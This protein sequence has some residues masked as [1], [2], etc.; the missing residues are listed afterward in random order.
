MEELT[1]IVKRILQMIPVLLIITFIIFFGMRLI[2]GDPAL[3]LVGNRASDEVIAATRAR[4]GSDE[5]LFTQYLL[6]L[7]QCL[8]FDFGES[9]T[10]RAPVTELFAQKAVITVSLTLMT[11]VF[12][13]LISFPLGYAA[14]VKHDSKIGSFIDS[15]SLTFVSVPEF[16]VGLVIMLI[17]ALRLKWFPVGGWGDTLG[18]RLHAL[19]LPAF[20]GALG[21]AAL[22][23]RNIRGNVIQVLD[24]DYVDFA[25][26][27]GLSPWKIRTR[28][29]FKNVLISTVTL[30]AMRMTY[31]LAGSI[32]IESVFALPGI[33]QMM[34]NAI[35]A[36]DYSIVQATVYLFSII[37]LLMNLLTDI[38]YSLLDPRVKLN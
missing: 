32:V 3:L 17:F 25:Y 24:K 12:A 1:Y 33:G 37:V 30:L 10:L 36:R 19:I 26:S 7:K 13:I 5:P 34:L 28:Y 15:L 9:M 23:L 21:T 27:K 20:T 11:I 8:T 6:F 14:G 2:P 18:E 35:L 22:V 38:A 4:L 29:I 16:L 31:M